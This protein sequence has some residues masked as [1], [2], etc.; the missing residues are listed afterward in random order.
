MV[1]GAGLGDSSSALGRDVSFGC[2][3]Y[4]NSLIRVS[5]CLYLGYF[6]R[7]GKIVQGGNL[8]VDSHTRS[9]RCQASFQKAVISGAYVAVQLCSVNVQHEER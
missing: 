9:L 6:G 8:R 2:W 7:A 3:G 1:S 4:N 5:R